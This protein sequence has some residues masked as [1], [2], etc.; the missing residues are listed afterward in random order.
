M[1]TTDSIAREVAR[2]SGDRDFERLRE[3]KGY[4][5][6]I[7]TELTMALRKGAVL[8]TATVTV[9]NGIGTLP[10]GVFSI[11]RIGNNSSEKYEIVDLQTFRRRQEKSSSL[12]TAYVQEEVPLWKIQVLDTNSS[13]FDVSVDYLFTS[14]NAAT[15][16]E[17]YEN[18]IKAGAETLYHLRRSGREKYLSMLQE[19]NRLK[20]LY[21][22]NQQ[23]NDNV[24][25]QMKSLDQISSEA[26]NDDSVTDNDFLNRS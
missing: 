18:V 13:P 24:V 17:Y 20:N 11:L 3:I 15:L 25:S 19:Y 12:L 7:V 6:D 26:G 5:E 8:K 9:T 4:V 21:L 16:P 2:R 1:S 14:D 23:Y 22:E 10:E